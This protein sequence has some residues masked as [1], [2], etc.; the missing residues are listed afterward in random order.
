M[1]TLHSTS[2]IYPGKSLTGFLIVVCAICALAGIASP[3]IPI[4]FT[5]ASLGIMNGC[6]LYDIAAIFLTGQTE[7]G[8][9]VINC[10][11]VAAFV[12]NMLI[13]LAL[14]V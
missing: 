8:R 11:T 10:R 3:M 6:L 14:I 1:K 7:E 13:I 5:W 4:E 9:G 12:I 2:T